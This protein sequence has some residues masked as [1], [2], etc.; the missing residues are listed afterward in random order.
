[1]SEIDPVI[2]E[3]RARVNGYLADISRTTSSV[4]RMLGAQEARFRRLEVEASRST[5]AIGNSFKALGAGLAAY[6]TVDIARKFLEIADEAK[7]LDAQ[8]RLATAGFGTFGQAQSDVRR[9]SAE[10][11]S[12]LSETATLYGNFARGIKE[13]GGSQADAARAT[14]T[15]SKTLKISGADANQAASATLQFG[16]A[17]ASG[18]L[19]G[20]ELNSILEA[21]PRLASLLAQSMGQPIGAIKQM[22]EEG[23]LTSDKL[24]RALTDTR[25]TAGVDAEFRELPVT[26]NDAMAQVHNAAVITFGAFDRGGQFSTALA[27]FITGGSDGFQ[28]LEKD[29]LDFG[30]SVRS[31]LEGL[32]SAF[33]PL[34]DAAK[35]F[36]DYFERGV[37]NLKFDPA[38]ELRDADKLTKWFANKTWIGGVLKDNGYDAST[39]LEGNYRRRQQ[40]SELELRR[41]NGL[42]PA[43]R[44]LARI[45]EAN[46]GA[47]RSTTSPTPL[48][49]ARP[50]TRSRSGGGAAQSAEVAAR[51]AEADRLR[52]I[53][54][55]AATQRESARYDD[56]ILAAKAALA[57]AATDIL[58]YQLDSIESERTQR[59]ADIE[60]QV[61]LGQLGR[62]EADR[63]ILINSELASLQKELVN[64]RAQEAE[65]ARVTARMQDRENTL[66]SESQ[67]A[68]TMSERREI[69]MRILDLAYQQEEAAIRSAAARGEIADLDEA[70]ANMRKRR[71][72]DQEVVRRQT[73]GPLDR[74]ARE[75]DQFDP[76]ARVEAAVVEELGQVRDGIHSAISNMLGTKDPIIGALI[77]M[78]IQNVLMKPLA[79]ALRGAGSGG[80]LFGGILSGLGS[81]FG[82]IG[83][84]GGGNP[85]GWGSG[86][87]LG[88]NW[89]VAPGRASGGRVN[90]G[91]LYR[92]N[93]A[94]APGRVEGFI[95]DQSGTIIPLG[96]MD[97]L[98]P[99]ATAGGGQVI[100]KVVANDYFDAK[101]DQRA[102]AVAAPMAIASAS[103]G[104]K[105][106]E[107]RIARRS[108]N[109]IP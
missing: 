10:T 59:N 99:R 67:L 65:A 85:A 17:L 9:I 105:Q 23:Q 108:R 100:V 109:R 62:E 53:R 47:G 101:V 38:L 49:P 14:E 94:S 13:L 81:L 92:V 58:R 64:R 69:E 30:I 48:S 46:R 91:Q 72:V 27:N 55:D 3:F 107:R 60:T 75:T 87:N 106:A 50:S 21:S 68:A 8:L 33:E 28:D 84:L 31:A 43:S 88:N 82:G 32:G 40:E 97:A 90:A 61:K 93:E 102:T 5:G 89:G 54:D 51:R 70:L 2:F 44:A 20:D 18:A 57:T 104:S 71:A 25:F 73:E 103:E 6:M 95:P 79:E 4:D 52:S 12:G 29:A 74:W 66:R 19:R 37:G 1:M 80:G 11:R 77:D 7:K 76:K 45:S 16:Q 96:R 26:F 34:F 78:L 83:G 98:Q 41:K 22:G 24:V 56:D 36:F 86:I 42:T 63:R 39:N 15:F 35:S